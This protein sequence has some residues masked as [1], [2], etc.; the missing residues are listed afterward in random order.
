MSYGAAEDDALLD[1]CNDLM[2]QVEQQAGEIRFLRF[3][4]AEMQAHKVNDDDVIE[5]L[6]AVIE[7]NRNTAMGWVWD[8]G[9]NIEHTTYC[10]WC[11]KNLGSDMAVIREHV[12]AC[13]E[14][15]TTSQVVTHASIDT[16]YHDI[17]GC[18]GVLFLVNEKSLWQ[19]LRCNAYPLTEN[20]STKD[21]MKN[22]K[23]P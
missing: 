11:Q 12:T 13:R 21:T 19:C 6:H 18:G 23:A 5:Q 10:V 8:L 3:R 2:R 15:H 9:V 14:T 1:H 20:I 22:Y 16:L 7:Y 4:V 17:A